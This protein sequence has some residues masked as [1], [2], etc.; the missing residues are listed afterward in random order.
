[1]TI[2]PFQTFGFHG[3]RHLPAIYRHNLDHLIQHIPDRLIVE[4]E[5]FYSEV[6]KISPDS[7]SALKKI[8]ATRTD[9]AKKARVTL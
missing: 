3:S 9:A 6:L 2:P 1:M 8:I 7:A 5:E 4:G